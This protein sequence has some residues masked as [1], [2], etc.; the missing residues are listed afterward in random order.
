MRTRWL[1]AALAG[2]CLTTIAFAQGST[3]QPEADS[4][5]FPGSP[6]F[7][8]LLKP[9]ARNATEPPAAVRTPQAPASQSVERRADA[10]QAT[11]QARRKSKIF[12]WVDANGRVHF[13]DAPRDKNAKEIKIRAATRTPPASSPAPRDPQQAVDSD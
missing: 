11:T 10:P 5:A 3:V 6:N 2:S 9:P 12:K 8:E 1:V 4:P 7:P 13:G